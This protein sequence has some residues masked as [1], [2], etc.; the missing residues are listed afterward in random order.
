MIQR[1]KDLVG[2]L[3]PFSGHFMDFSAQSDQPQAFTSAVVDLTPFLLPAPP[4]PDDLT[5]EVRRAAL[6]PSLSGFRSAVGGTQV[7]EQ[8]NVTVNGALDPNAVAEQIDRLLKRR[9][10]LMGSAA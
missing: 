9:A 3:N 10:R 4:T 7:V 2:A 1:A 5:R 8:I 6:P